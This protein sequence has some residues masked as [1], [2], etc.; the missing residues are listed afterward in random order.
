[1]VRIPTHRQPTHPG[2]MLAKEFL[3]PMHISQRQLADALHVP[4]Q[5]INELVNQKRGITPSTSLRLAR[6][7]GMSPDFWLNLQVRWDLF[8]AE[9]SEQAD[10][11]QI[12]EFRS[13]KQTA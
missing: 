8:K 11:K 3:E 9:Q 4:Y 12:R 2:E 1:M 10:L 7:F 13:C 5:R 6:F